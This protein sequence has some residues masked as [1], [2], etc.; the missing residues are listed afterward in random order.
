MNAL[1]APSAPLS[2]SFSSNDLDG[3]RSKQPEAIAQQF[4][5]LFMSMLVK[6]MRQSPLGEG[7]F[8]GDGSDTYGGIFDT[9]M[10]QHLAENGGIG[11]AASIAAAIRKQT[12]E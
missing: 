11:M 1:S 4:E 12:D 6:E 10:G 5:G 7:L 9:F 8:P 3:L 2:P